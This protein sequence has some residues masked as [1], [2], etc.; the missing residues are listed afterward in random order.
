MESSNTTSGSVFSLSAAELIE[1]CGISAYPITIAT[2]SIREAWLPSFV[3][4]G[5]INPMIIKGTQ[6]LINC[7]K[8]YFAVTT[9]FKMALVA[10]LPSA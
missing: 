6:K 7:P 1:R 2:P 9:T 3:I 4:E 5:A 8:I 10:A